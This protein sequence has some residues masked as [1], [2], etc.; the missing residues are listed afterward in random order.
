MVLHARTASTTKTQ[1]DPWVNILRATAES[2]AAIVGGADSVSTSPFDEA[3]GTP[4][5]SGPPAGAQ[6][7]AHPARRVEPQP[8]RRPRGRQLLP[9]AAHAGHRPRGVDRAAAHRGAGRHGPALTN[10]DVARVLT[11][12]RAARDKAVRTRRLPIV[13]V[14]EFPHLGETP[15]QRESRAA[16]STEPATSGPLPLRPV[17]V[18]ESFEALRD[19][20]DRHLAAHGARPQAFLASL[21]TVAEHTTRS[22]WTAN[23]LAAG[24]IEPADAHGFADVADAAARFAASGATLAVISGPDALY[25]EWVPALTAALKAKGARAV[26][27]AGRPGDHE[28]AFR[29]AGVDVFFYAGADLFALLSSLHQQL[30]V[31]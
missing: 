20:S 10:G 5:A 30:G 19:A 13:G 3:L 14:S 6:H 11:E 29:A 28:A 2:F 12:T 25:P 15:V 7:A 26:A 17:R 22:T 24:G 18:A 1:R 8:R 9:G 21:G 23:V 31:A 4:D 16:A 27:V